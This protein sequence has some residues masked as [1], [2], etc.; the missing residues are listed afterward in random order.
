MLFIFGYTWPA[1]YHA[2]DNFF[3]SEPCPDIDGA[4]GRIA[5]RPHTGWSGHH[6]AKLVSCEDLEGDRTSSRHLYGDRR[7]GERGY[8]AR[9]RWPV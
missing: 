1:I 4:A 6:P 5:D 9:G 7:H 3:L 2:D 8:R